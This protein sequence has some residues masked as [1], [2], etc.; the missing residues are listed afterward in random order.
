MTDAEWDELLAE[1]KRLRVEIVG[2]LDA[3][4]AELAGL[5]AQLSGTLA[6]IKAQ[7]E[8]IA[9]LA[10]QLGSPKVRP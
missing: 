9:D 5:R 6:E 10:R 8:V 4:G 7:G 1:A 3:L 2:K